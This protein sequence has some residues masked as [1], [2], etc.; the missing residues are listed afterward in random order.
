MKLI[1]WWYGRAYSMNP[2]IKK[3]W[4]EALRSGQYKQGQGYLKSGDKYC[5]LGVLCNLAKVDGVG[6]WEC[7][8]HAT[9]FSCA[10]SLDSRVLPRDVQQWAG[11]PNSVGVYEV[12]DDNDK[13]LVGLNDC[14]TSF[15]EIAD[16]IDKKF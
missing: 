16:V 2:A 7:H 5:C 11:I 3:R 14:G 15:E 12:N 4:I 8:M 6:K 13:T 9:V 10:N 1:N